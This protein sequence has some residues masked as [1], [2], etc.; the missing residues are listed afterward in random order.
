MQNEESPSSFMKAF[1]HNQRLNL[2]ELIPVRVRVPDRN[3][4]MSNPNFEPSKAA[5][6]I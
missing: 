5:L 3:G 1:K 4:F 6:E 2:D